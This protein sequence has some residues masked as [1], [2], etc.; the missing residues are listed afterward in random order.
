MATVQRGICRT[1][2]AGPRKTIQGQMKRL[3]FT[4]LAAAASACGSVEPSEF[5]QTFESAQLA[6]WRGDLMAAQSLVDR[7]IG[8]AASATDTEEIWRLRLLRAEILLARL[9]LTQAESI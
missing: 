9:Q 5:R 1:M 4:L 2:E 8:G 7:G 6:M 3:F